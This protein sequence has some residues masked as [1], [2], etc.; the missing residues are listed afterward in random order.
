MSGI[1]FSSAEDL[2]IQNNYGKIPAHEIAAMLGK[3][4]TSITIR[5]GRLGLAFRET[6]PSKNGFISK[7]WTEKEVTELHRKYRRTPVNELALQ[8]GRTKDQIIQKASSLGIKSRIP[9]Y[10]GRVIVS[11]NRDGTVRRVLHIKNG[12]KIR[13]SHTVWEKHNGPVPKGM[14]VSV[15]TG[16]P[17]DCRHIDKLELVTQRLHMLRNNP[18]LTEDEAIAYDLIGSI[19]QK[20]KEK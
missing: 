9:H 20:I 17:L 12:K 2:V 10:E 8:F 7:R 5:A 4:R 19:K 6:F 11:M 16:N 14:C 3:T 15:K 18:R 1:R 13:Y